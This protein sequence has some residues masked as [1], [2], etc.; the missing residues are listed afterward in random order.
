LK[1]FPPEVRAMSDQKYG[2]IALTP[3]QRDALEVLIRAEIT[4]SKADLAEQVKNGKLHYAR[5][6]EERAKLF[7]EILRRFTLFVPLT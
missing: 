5:L 6:A 4:R 7:T 2:A 1:S 3:E